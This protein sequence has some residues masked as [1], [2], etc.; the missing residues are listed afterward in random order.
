[1]SNST[2]W[3]VYDYEVAMF[4]M[5]TSL[6][7]SKLKLNDIIEPL[8][9]IVRTELL[10]LHTR[11]L[12]EIFLCRGNEPDD[13]NINKLLPNFTS[14]HILKLRDVYGKRSLK[15]SPCWTI[16]KMFAHPTTFRADKYDY[17]SILNSI[18]PIMEKIIKEIKE[19][20]VQMAS[21]KPEGAL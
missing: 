11:I 15:G 18:I 9:R 8:F 10:L 16:N 7:G 13:L 1:M 5:C 21:I 4:E 17:T 19:Y 20:R 14:D 2:F 3:S 6:R 12:A